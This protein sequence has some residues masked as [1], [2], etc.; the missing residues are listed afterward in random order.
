[1]FTKL[2]EDQGFKISVQLIIVPVIELFFIALF[3]IYDEKK[4]GKAIS[5][6]PLVKFSKWMNEWPLPYNILG[7]PL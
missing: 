6:L 5:R 7:I 1:M 4:V 3:D 2:V